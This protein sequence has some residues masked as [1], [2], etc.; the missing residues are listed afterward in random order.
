MAIFSHRPPPRKTT[1]PGHSDQEPAILPASAIAE[2]RTG[3]GRNAVRCWHSHAGNSCSLSCRH[4]L[5]NRLESREAALRSA[6]PASAH[7]P[8]SGAERHDL[9]AYAGVCARCIVAPPSLAKITPGKCD[10]DESRVNH[11]TSRESRAEAPGTEAEG[12]RQQSWLG[13]RRPGARGPSPR[14]RKVLLILR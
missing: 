9:L 7:F 3:K 13:S 14:G 10:Q 11:H 6:P 12:P 1:P 8:D 4:D 5:A 2:K